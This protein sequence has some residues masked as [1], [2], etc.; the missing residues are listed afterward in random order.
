MEKR[1]RTKIGKSPITWIVVIVLC[2]LLITYALI[3]ISSLL[4]GFMTSLKDPREFS[5]LD[6]QNVMGLPSLN[7]NQ[8]PNSWDEV[9]RLENYRIIFENL[10]YDYTMPFYMGQTEV[11]HEVK[12]VN[13]LGML[14]N[15]LFYT[16]GGALIYAI[17]PC[18]T[19]Y[20]CAKYDEFKLSGA[21]FV[22]YLFMMSMPI[23]GNYPTELTFLRNIGIYDTIWGNYI[24]KM[25][26]SGMYFF[27]YYAYFKGVS[28]TYREAA[29]IDG[30]SQFRVMVTIYFP[31]AINMISTVFLIQFVTLWND[32]QTPLMY[33]PTHPTLAFGIYLLNTGNG[34]GENLRKLYYTTIRMAGCMMLAVPITIIF[35]IFKERLMGDVSLGGI[36]E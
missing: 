33:L 34:S 6:F 23:V 2:A 9:F 25:T 16:I 19:A 11:V 10:T 8:V 31:L 20:L 30:A 12:D 28:N 3:L 13:L 15:T 1:K 24:Q 22:V 36:K 27:V 14:W 32:Y 18:M 21:I 26:G 17:M 5:D 7:R 29:E 35:V 4:W